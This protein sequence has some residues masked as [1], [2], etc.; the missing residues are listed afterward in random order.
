MFC[1]MF[2][3][4]CVHS[5]FTTLFI[6]IPEQEALPSRF[7]WE[8]IMN[9]FLRWREAASVL[10]AAASWVLFIFFYLVLY[11]CFAL[12]LI[13]DLD[14]V[15]FALGSSFNSVLS[16]LIMCKP[17]HGFVPNFPAV[18]SIFFFYLLIFP[19]SSQIYYDYQYTSHLYGI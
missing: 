18:F 8:A 14:L 13:G 15:W 7:S 10:C 1:V 9:V 4:S 16:L 3:S 17:L 5:I 19:A 11:I 2:S 12:V 6:I